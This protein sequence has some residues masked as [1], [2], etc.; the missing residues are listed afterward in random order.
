MSAHATT[1]SLTALLNSLHT[2]LQT[3]TQ[4]LPTLHSQLGL[5]PSALEDD[6]EAL[7]EELVKGVEKQVE[8]RR[9]EVEEWMSRC[10]VVEKECIRYS[11]ALGGNIKSTGNSV[12][13][14]RKEAVL[15]RRYDLVAEH[16][17]KL[18]QL[19]HSKLE[20]LTTITNRINS[21]ARTL[22]S[23][24]FGPDVREPSA[25]DGENVL[26]PESHRDV[27]PERF[28]KLEK[29]LVRGKAEVGKRLSQLSGLFV[30][31]DWLYSE[32]GIS[33]PT[34]DDLSSRSASTST[35]PTSDPFLSTPTPS[36]RSGSSTN[37]LR[38]E[39]AASLEVEYQR[40]FARFVARIEE[41]DD[42]ALTDN[43]GV[44][45][46]LES[47]D[48]APGLLS[49][50]K[51]LQGS[52]EDLK[53]RREAHIQGMYDQLEGLWR[54]L[55]VG[56]ADMDAFVE[57]H[58]GSTEDTVREYEEELERM[59][60]LK[61]DRMGTFIESARQEIVKLWDDLMV[62]GDER[63]DFAPFV[64]DENTE[65]LLTIHED[66]VRRLKEER[67]LKAP[68]LASVRKYFDICEE[69]KE[70]ALAA[71]DQTRLLGRGPR[72]PGRL[73]R[74]EKMR[75]RVSKEKPRLEQDLLVSIPAWEQDTSR[76]FLVHGE[77]FLQMLT[78][79]VAAADQENKRRPPRAGSVPPRATTPVN[80]TNSYVPGTRAGAVTPAVRSSSTI[81]SH[82]LPN[83]RQKLND[84]T[85]SGHRTGR[86]PLGNH[87]G[88]NTQ[89]R[90]GS[91]TKVP[92]KT[93]GTISSVPRPTT[94]AIPKP[95][96]QY[97]AL[98]YGRVPGTMARS[99]GMRS[100]S[101]GVKVSSARVHS[102]F[103]KSSK[104]IPGA[105]FSML[106]KASRAKRES[107][108][109]RSSTDTTETGKNVG[110]GSARWG[111][112]LAGS[113]KEEEGEGY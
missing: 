40:T 27:S 53:R 17:E 32:L 91:P 65:E 13:E 14:L 20:Q 23:T 36:S 86:A 62:G 31:I 22:G 67:R 60:E 9:K 88:N 108:K 71:A 28:L 74:E 49:W 99:S 98:G 16:Q 29:E 102:K 79:T 64:D 63:A 110:I 33:A 87:R 83:K 11:K 7:Q 30:Q 51:G 73:L 45:Y 50:A 69:E 25:A 42:E 61:R 97:H 34:L 95:G 38:D 101:A 85:V 48:P 84:S 112:G 66:E 100:A 96:T 47:V 46:G 10:D 44:P 58:R 15:P 103:Q 81:S 82:S 56:E 8:T 109:P 113:V 92:V 12:G 70:L 75:K 26:D 54:R 105:G 106:R 59:L 55:G 3:Q 57:N 89:A 80:S 111:A 77:S 4:L 18:R 24:F 104:S 6:L 107:F 5:P 19:Y 68:L 43:Q 21:L 78:E 37:F 72:D 2:H 94:L 52:L 35:T 39:Q 41:A 93:P 90:P 1:S 76:P